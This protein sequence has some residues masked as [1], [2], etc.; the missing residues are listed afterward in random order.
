LSYLFLNS[1]VLST[2]LILYF[3]AESHS[4]LNAQSY[5]YQTSVDLVANSTP[6]V[7]LLSRLN[8]FR[9]NLDKRLLFP[10]PESPMRTTSIA[11]T[12]QQT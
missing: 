2:F 1:I 3:K 5:L 12:Q 9:V 7:L 10:T 6:M 4:I 8:S 11:E